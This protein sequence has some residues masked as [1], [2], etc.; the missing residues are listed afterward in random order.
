MG[1]TATDRTGIVMADTE[2]VITSWNAGAERLFGHRA[3]DA[4]GQS[5]DLIVPPE[6]REAHW[7]GFH[8]A[9]ATGDCRLDR[10]ATNLP[11]VHGDGSR[12]VLPGRFVFLVDPRDAVVGAM[13]IYA[14]P[15]GAEEAWGAVLPLEAG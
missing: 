2:G 1:T 12:R 6:H 14:E 8:R 5:L 15:A 4:I 3:D 13:A 7:A 9:I 10:Q 11:V